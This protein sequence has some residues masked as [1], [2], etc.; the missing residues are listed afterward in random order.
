MRSFIILTDEDLPKVL[1]LLVSRGES[2]Y[3]LVSTKRDGPRGYPYLGFYED[4]GG[5]WIL[6]RE[7]RSRPGISGEGFL[8]LLQPLK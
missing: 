1:E 2:I 8:K 4:A 6:A 3:N 5:Q 7:D